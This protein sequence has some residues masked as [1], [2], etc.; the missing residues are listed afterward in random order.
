V[1]LGPWRLS[2]YTLLYTLAALSACTLSYFRLKRLPVRPVVLLRGI[3]LTTVA[4]FAGNYLVRVVPTVQ[5]YLQSGVW[6][7]VGGGSYIGGLLSGV[8]VFTLYCRWARIPLLRAYDQVAPALLLGQAIGRL[9]CLAAGCCYGRPADSWLALYLPNSQGDW[10][11]RYPT[12]LL[13]AGAYLAVLA[14]LLV[15]E[16]AGSPQAG[17]GRVA[18]VPGHGARVAPS[19][20]AGNEG[21]GLPAGLLFLL[22]VGLYCLERFLVEF[23][24]A[25]TLPVLGPV[26]WAQLYTV[27]GMVL[28]TGLII[29]Q[30]WPGKRVWPGS[31]GKAVLAQAG[32]RVSAPGGRLQ[33]APTVLGQ[34][35]EKKEGLSS[36]K[37]PGAAARRPGSSP[38]KGAHR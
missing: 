27:A 5:R 29:R 23:L 34:V 6:E 24:R 35:Q 3:L 36:D 19:S 33:P 9:G 38:K 31:V 30:V 8:L 21:Q 32:G 15:V 17:Q 12:Q 25:D 4:G 11:L 14:L 10:A 1:E 7:W 28:A 13:S 37:G 2:T 26:S 16:K 18:P 22:Y 20:P